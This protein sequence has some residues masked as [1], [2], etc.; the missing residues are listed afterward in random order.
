MNQIIAIAVGGALGAVLRYWTSTGVY[1]LL[2]RSFPYGTLSVNVIGSLLMGVLSV[3]LI[4]RIDLDPVWRAGLLIGFL[5]AFTTFS[6]FSFE[7]LSLI[8]QGAMTKAGINML[9]SVTACVGAVWVGLLV[10]R[11]L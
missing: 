1:S 6:T 2:G 4:E 5:G 11:A 10:G 3:V 8:E 9:L 7:T